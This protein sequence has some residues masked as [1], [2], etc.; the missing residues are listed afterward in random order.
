MSQAI[1]SVVIPFHNEKQNLPEL[2]QRL[3]STAALMA[4]D[5]CLEMVFVD[6]GSTDEGS[7]VLEQ[8]A[9]GDERV[10]L[11]RLSRNWGSHPAL[12][13]GLKYAAG[14]AFAA[15]SADLQDP[16]EMLPAFWQAFRKGYQVV[17]GVRQSREDPFFKSLWA[18]CFYALFRRIALPSLPAGGVDTFLISRK[19]R[20]E[21]LAMPERCNLPYY[22][23]IYLGYPAALVPYRRQARRAGRSK[24]TFARRL[25]SAADAFVAFTPIPLRLATVFGMI[26]L[27]AAALWAA[28]CLSGLFAWSFSTWVLF[29]LGGVQLL[30]LGILGEYIWRIAEQV[31]QRPEY[32]VAQCA[33][34]GRVAAD[35]DGTHRALT[36][37]A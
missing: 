30:S 15:L 1:L 8:V 9:A 6:D 23:I 33:R 13:A 28:G 24:W 16:P 32:A 31:R 3:C 26:T 21:L 25:R 2:Y 29:I 11:L 34:L 17:W 10:V 12:K 27:M 18:R 36:S 4:S 5:V 22:S 19:V 7:A 35:K 14:D 20:D 37:A